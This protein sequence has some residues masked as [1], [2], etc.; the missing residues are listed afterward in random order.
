M[1]ANYD[2]AE[3]KARLGYVSKRR[4]V[5]FAT[6]CSERLFPLY[7]SFCRHTGSGDPERL[8][9][10]LDLAWN[11]GSPSISSFDVQAR[12]TTVE[13]LMPDDGLVPSVWSPLGDHAATAVA[14]SLR[15][16][17]SG[18]TENGVWAARQLVEAA[19]YLLQSAQ[20][21]HTYRD[22]GEPMTFA[23]RAVSTALVAA[24]TRTAREL[25]GTAVADGLHLLRMAEGSLAA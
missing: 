8:R 6:A 14:Y 13:G 5:L 21:I 11:V 22:N 15:L 9:E 4:Q 1:T 23:I 16:W 25:R 10:A 24:A 12:L 19:D 17:L 20:P 18:Q 3:I 7:E 2:E